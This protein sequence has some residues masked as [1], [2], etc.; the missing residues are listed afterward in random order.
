LRRY[1]L[2]LSLAALTCLRFAWTT[3]LALIVLD[4]QNWANGRPPEGW[5]IKLTHGKA[6]ISGCLEANDSCV[7]LRSAKS[8]FGLERDIDVD[9]YEMRYL[10]WRW[11]V[12]RLPDG[13]DFR[14]VATDDQAAQVL[15]AFADRHILT[16][17]WDSNAPKGVMQS[18]SSIPLVHIF[19]V[20]CESGAAQINRWVS[21]SRN[22]SGDYERAYGKSAP[23]VRGV[24]I[25]INSQHTGTFAESYF[26][27]VAFREAPE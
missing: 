19:A 20:V 12:T 3:P 17:I 8:S 1:A 26:G 10:T 2:I 22:L 4:P 25:Q 5:Q 23:H 14:S 6:D 27:Q 15:V 9:P 21:E 13:G 7:R 11:K 16:Y 18:S 24:R